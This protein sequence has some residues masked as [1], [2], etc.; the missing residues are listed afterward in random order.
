MDVVQCFE[1][2]QGGH[3]GRQRGAQLL[4]VR[5]ALFMPAAA[6]GLHVG[7]GVTAPGEL[8]RIGGIG[9]REGDVE[10]L[11]VDGLRGDQFGQR[12]GGT[13]LDAKRHGMKVHALQHSGEAGGIDSIA[14]G[15]SAVLR[16]QHQ[17]GRT[18]AEVVE[19]QFIGASRVRV[20]N[21]LM[22]GPRHL[23]GP[24]CAGAGQLAIKRFEPDS[25]G[26]TM[27]QLVLEG[28]AFQHRLDALHPV[29]PAKR[30]KRGGQLQ[31][32]H[33]KPSLL[34]LRKH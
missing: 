25:V 29:I 9:E 2:A 31:I 22:K 28:G 26:R 20:V 14:A 13:A 5:G 7:A 12:H 17:A 4:C 27:D 33:V 24:R 1:R 30:R 34:Q 11:G 18:I 32:T 15:R 8:C 10:A 16:H 19:R 23:R 6:V 21:A 3:G